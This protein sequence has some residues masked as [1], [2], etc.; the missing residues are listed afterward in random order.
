MSLSLAVMNSS[1]FRHLFRTVLPGIVCL[2]MVSLAW[3]SPAEEA[4]AKVEESTGELVQKLNE[5]RDTFYKDPEAFYAIMDSALTSVVDFER[6]AL[7][8]MGKY[9]RGASETQVTAFTDVFKRSMFRAYGKT[10]V[11]T[12]EFKV[13]ILGGEDNVRDAKRASVNLEVISST[14]NKYPVVYAMYLNP[15]RGWLLENVVVNGVNVGLAFRD[16]FEQQYNE[17]NGNIDSVVSNWSP[18]IVDEQLK[19]ATESDD[20]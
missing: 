19:S 13:N 20:V 6:I 12:G 2:F 16:K 11:E 9:R 5:E 14:G 18:A 10:L 3:A 8:V 15:Q 7:R 1:T 17:F 4:A